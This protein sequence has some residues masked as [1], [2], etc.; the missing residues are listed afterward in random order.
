MDA[1]T[2]SWS[3][4]MTG[5]FPDRDP[6]WLFFCCSHSISRRMLMNLRARVQAQMDK[7]PHSLQCLY[8]SCLSVTS[9]QMLDHRCFG[10]LEASLQAT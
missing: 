6:W 9:I 5:G 4:A 1:Y 7:L 8:I 2:G 3:W 10:S